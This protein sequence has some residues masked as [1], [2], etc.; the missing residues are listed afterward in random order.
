VGPARPAQQWHEIDGM[1]A[2]LWYQRRRQRAA[3]DTTACTKTSWQF[4]TGG[5]TLAAWLA[6]EQYD[7]SGA[8]TGNTQ[9]HS[10][11]LGPNTRVLQALVVI[12]TSGNN[13]ELVYYTDDIALEFESAFP[14]PAG[15]KPGPTLYRTNFEFTPLPD[16]EQ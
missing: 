4:P 2:A 6:G 5:K 9:C 3:E 14:A 12:T 7:D 8:G 10:L 1:G 11:V 13:R 15:A 16:Q